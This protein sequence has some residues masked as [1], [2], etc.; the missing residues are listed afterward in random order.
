[1]FEGS[2][3]LFFK[4]KKKRIFRYIYLLQDTEFNSIISIMYSL[5]MS[6]SGFVGFFCIQFESY[7]INL[8]R[9]FMRRKIMWVLGLHQWRATLLRSESSSPLLHQC[10]TRH[11]L[12]KQ[13]PCRYRPTPCPKQPRASWFVCDRSSDLP[14]H[15][16]QLVSCNLGGKS[17]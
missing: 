9:D 12:F 14:H 2:F 8:G 16:H 5:V 10:W 6:E 7:G 3:P 11:V 4:K 15:V 13:T 1:M 17:L